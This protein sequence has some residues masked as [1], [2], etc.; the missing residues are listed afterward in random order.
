MKTVISF[1]FILFFVFGVYSSE[2][3]NELASQVPKGYELEGYEELQNRWFVKYPHIYH[4]RQCE[5]CTYDVINYG[6]PYS[7]LLSPALSETPINGTI[8]MICTQPHEKYLRHVFRESTQA[9]RAQYNLSYFFTLT[10]D[11]SYSKGMERLQKEQD[12]YHDLLV[13]NHSN[14]YSNLALTVLLTYHYLHSLHLPSRFIVKMDADCAVNI[15]LL[16]SILHS[17]EATEMKYAYIGDCIST[18]YNTVLPHLKNYIPH[19]IIQ[20][21]PWIYAYA[22]GG[23]YVLSYNTLPPLLVAIRHFP[24]ITH[25]EDAMVGRAMYKMNIVCQSLNKEYWLARYGCSEGDVCKNYVAIH[26]KDSN[27]ETNFY[28]SL[29][30]N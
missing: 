22:R 15:P 19:E 3:N 1:I 11:N 10:R 12:H 18:S 6:K 29:F 4:Y 24:F 25:H 27:R 8:L 2:L 5:N 7:V 13:F 16:M 30:S 26:P 14:S 21:E 17:S 28:Y 9:L 20:D 23:L